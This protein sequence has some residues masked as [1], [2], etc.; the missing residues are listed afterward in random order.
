MSQFTWWRRFYPTQ[1]LDKGQ[2]FKIGSKLLQR[3]EFGE[4]EFEPLSA[5]THLEEEIYRLKCEEIDQMEGY[6]KD[7]LEEFKIVERKKKNKRVNVML[8]HHLQ[9]EHNRMI[10]LRDKLVKEFSLDRTYVTDTIES[11]D[12][13]TR[14]LYFYLKAVKQ[15]RQIKTS[16][17]INLIPR[18]QYEQPRHI[19]KH[20]Q[21]VHNKTWQKI[22]SS[23][24]PCIAY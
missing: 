15:D 10:E 14:E 4:F 1:K 2:F 19:L 11:F 24:N 5:E 12:G 22:V 9:W 7:T 18:M 13:T 21:K 20:K 16:D 3:I 23:D 6:H 17:E 8:S